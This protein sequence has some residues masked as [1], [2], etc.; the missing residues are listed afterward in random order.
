MAQAQPVLGPLLYASFLFII[1]F[2]GAAPGA[3]SPEQLLPH[4]AQLTYCCTGFTILIAIIAGAYER[5]KDQ[6]VPEGATPLGCST[7]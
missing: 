4:A 2:V 3:P 7:Q 5:V 1:L 6:D